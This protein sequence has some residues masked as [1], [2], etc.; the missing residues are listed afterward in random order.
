VTQQNAA[1]VEENTAAAQSMVEQ[2]R[3]LEKLMSFFTLEEGTELIA[4]QEHAEAK[5]V[6]K[7]RPAATKPAVKK[8]VAAKRPVAAK[9]P[10]KS[11][12][13]SNASGYSDGWDEF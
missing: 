12:K 5:P 13:A 4:A 7:V 3:A 10:T 2:A 8:P 9:Q 1:L 6:E 11:A